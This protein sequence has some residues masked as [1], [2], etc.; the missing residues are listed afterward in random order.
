MQTLGLELPRSQA[1]QG[2]TLLIWGASSSIGSCGVQLGAA[3]G[4]EVFAIASMRNHDLLKSIGATECFDYHNTDLVSDIVRRLRGRNIV[5]AYDAISQPS[6]IRTL[7][8]IL[9]QCEGRKLIAAIAPGAEAHAKHDVSVKTNFG[10]DVSKSGIG[11]RIWHEFLPLALAAGEFQ[12]RPSAAVVG[13]GLESVQ[14]AINLLAQG[15]SAKK[16]VVTL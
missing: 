9:Y 5:G 2:K 4:Y 6:T 13:H 11:A 3:A 10:T 16:L 12:Y 7:S 14:K 15:V 8:K 1:G